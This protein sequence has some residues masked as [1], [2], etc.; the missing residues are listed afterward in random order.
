MMISKL[1]ESDS[2]FEKSS[3][4]MSK[5]LGIFAVFKGQLGAKGELNFLRQM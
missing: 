5:I 1:G 2:R 3:T 4:K